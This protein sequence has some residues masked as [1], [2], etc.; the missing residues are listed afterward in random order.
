MVIHVVQPGDSIYSIAMEYSVPMSQIVMDNDLENAA[1]LVVGQA[2]VVRFPDQVHTVL[3]G[4]TLSGLSQQYGISLRQLYRNNPILGGEPV[5]FPGQTIV[6]SYQQE[7][8]LGTLSVNG[9]AYPFI[10]KDLLQQTVPYLTFLTPFTYG[11]TPQGG[12]I[13]LDDAVLIAMA[14]EG[15]AQALMHLSTLTEEGNF[16]NELAHLVLNDL[17]V[18]N[19][20]IDNIQQTLAQRGYRGLDVDFEFVFAEDA[21]L[22][23]NFIARLAERLNPSGYPVIAALAPKTS[24]TQRGLLYEGHN[25][26]AIGAAANEILLMTYEWGY[27]LSQIGYW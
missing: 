15:G 17:T 11:I 16:S 19:I 21:E 12:L 4:E 10:D 7:E 3:P 13:D 20:L 22:Y 26:R 5:L 2:L 9:Y 27:T 23:A 24:A 6:L 18:Q 8:K 25:Y 1:R 14:R